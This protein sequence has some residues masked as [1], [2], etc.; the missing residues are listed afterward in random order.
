MIPTLDQFAAITF[1]VLI[2]PPDHV[3]DALI[4]GDRTKTDVSRAV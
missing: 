3:H 1:A 4:G 2:V